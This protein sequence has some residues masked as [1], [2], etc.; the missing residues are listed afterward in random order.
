MWSRRLL[1]AGL[2]PWDS[3]LEERC[4]RNLDIGGCRIGGFRLHG[5]FLGSSSKEIVVDGSVRRVPSREWLTLSF[6]PHENGDCPSDS[7]LELEFPRVSAPLLCG[8]APVCLQISGAWVLTLPR[9]LCA[10]G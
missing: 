7:F 9:Y 4:F 8:G 10:T 3:A 2:L 5:T 1:F 6:L